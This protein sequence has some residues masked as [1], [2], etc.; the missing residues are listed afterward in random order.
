MLNRLLKMGREKQKIRRRGIQVL[1][2]PSRIDA[3]LEFNARRE[4]I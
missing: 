3:T 2:I 1:V 4:T